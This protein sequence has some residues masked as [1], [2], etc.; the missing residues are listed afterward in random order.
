MPADSSAARAARQATSSFPYSVE[1]ISN[2][3]SW[4]SL[5]LGAEFR[6]K[7]WNR[8][9][10][11]TDAAILPVANL[12]NEDSHYLHL[13]SDLGPAPNRTDE[14]TGWGYQLKSELRLD[15]T[16]NWAIGAGVRYW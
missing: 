16:E 3:A 1:V 6:A 12:W 10:M 15:V 9:T 2:K 7:L 11:R 8:L 14:G 5:R 4:S 13:R